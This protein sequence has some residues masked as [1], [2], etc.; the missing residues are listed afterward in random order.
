VDIPF[1]P[2]LI[3]DTPSVVIDLGRLRANVETAAQAA[4]AHGVRLRPHAKT[5]KMLEVAQLQLDAGAIGLQVA[6]LGEAEVFADGGVVDIFVGYPIVGRAKLRRLTEL[7][8]RCRISVAVDSLAVAAPLSEL[9]RTWDQPLPVMLEVDTGGRRTGAASGEAAVDLARRIDDLEGLT[10]VGVFTHEGH[11]YAAGDSQE[12]ETVAREACA[13]LVEAAEL[14][15]SRSGRRRPS[16][17]PSRAPASRRRGP[18]RTSSTT[19]FSSSSVRP[20]SMTSRRS[21]SRLSSRDQL[22]TG[23]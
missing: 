6:K 16:P 17:L 23:S 18:G 12:R 15:R 8:A 19:A 11:V 14:I 10:L 21:S 5:H 2:D 1:D 9:A 4:A 7:A 13:N 22:R 20:R 3:D